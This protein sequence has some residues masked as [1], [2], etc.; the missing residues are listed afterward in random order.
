MRFKNV[1]S[2]IGPVMLGPSSSHT[3]GAAR[4]GYAVRALLAEQPQHAVITLYGSFAE[5]Y[6][7]HGTDLAL[8]GGL[9]GLQT[10]DEKIK[11]ALS[12]AESSGIDIEFRIGKGAAQHPNTAK[13]EA[14][15][16]SG[17]V[18]VIGASIG[19]GNIRIVS[20]NGFE[21]EF[22][23]ELPV[24]VLTHEDRPGVL[25][26]VTRILSKHGINIGYMD[27]DRKSRSGEAMT[28]LEIDGDIPV[29][30]EYELCGAK[31]IR[32][33]RVVRWEQEWAGP[34]PTRTRLKEGEEA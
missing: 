26:N 21:V 16:A 22:G 14:K 32:D 23:S 17:G 28:V 10:D 19:G 6:E 3:A 25:A 31:W 13:I 33:V 12:L 24:I 7:G 27:V 11:D 2:I 30:A 34:N 5:T 9:L 8:A 20:V 4:I 1:F 29:E 18:E 15:G